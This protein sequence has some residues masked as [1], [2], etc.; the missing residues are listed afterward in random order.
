M[1]MTSS[2]SG[3]QNPMVAYPGMRAMQKVASDISRIDQ[4]NATRRPTRSPR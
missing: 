4:L 3:A 1:R 2:R